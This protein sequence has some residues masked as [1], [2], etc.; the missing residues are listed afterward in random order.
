MPEDVFVHE[1]GLCESD[2]VGKGTRI[3]AFAHV[4]KGAVVGEGCNIGETSFVE[5]GAVIGNHCTIKNG[6]SVWDKVTLED[7]VFIGPNAVLTNDLLP[8]C[9]H[10]KTPDDF[11]PTLIKEGASIGANATIVCG[12][13]IGRNAMV[14]AGAVVTRDVP[15]HVLVIGNPARQRGFV[16]DCGRRMEPGIRCSCGRLYRVREGRVRE[17]K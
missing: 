16:C 12:V 13:V 10:K 6:V 3:W 8:R 17:E 15:D 4:M 7:Y 9:K 1:K 2:R 11:L 5:S 14:G